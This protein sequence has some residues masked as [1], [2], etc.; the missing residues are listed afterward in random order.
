M[1]ER[2]QKAKDLDL[3]LILTSCSASTG[4]L[5]FLVRRLANMRGYQ[6]GA[7]HAALLVDGTLL[8]WGRGKCGDSIIFPVLDPVGLLFAVD[9]QNKSAWEQ[10]K[11]AMKWTLIATAAAVA[12]V[13]TF[14]VALFFFAAGA[15]FWLLGKLNENQLEKLSVVCTNYN[16]Y[17]IYDPY[18]NNCQKFVSGKYTFVKKF[19]FFIIILDATHELGLSCKFKG[20]MEKF[21]DRLKQNG[22]SDFIFQN[23]TFQT[24]KELDDF[25]KY[26]IDFKKLDTDDQKLLFGYA[27]VF[28]EYHKA[29]PDDPRWISSEPEFWAQIW[30]Q[31][32]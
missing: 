10:V 3:K 22:T 26:R 7:L 18:N 27:H 9:I 13:L 17:K 19:Y 5:G 2:R 12:T 32:R 31:Q 25:A 4:S 28:D 24:R 21:V 6:F 8:E 1:E 14:G 15:A 29:D 11:T 23:Q 30:E 16:R 20:E